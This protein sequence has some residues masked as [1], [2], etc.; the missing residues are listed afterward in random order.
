MSLET[1]GLCDRGQLVGRG[2]RVV[3]AAVGRVLDLL[4]G[5]QELL[6]LAHL[7]LQAAEVVVRGLELAL[8]ERSLLVELRL[9]EQINEQLIICLV[10][11]KLAL[12]TLL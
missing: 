3:L 5:E 10:V 9:V 7:G 2:L 11:I 6:V 4:R 8:E 1:R 12:I